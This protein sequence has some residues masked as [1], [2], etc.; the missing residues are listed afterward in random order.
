MVH[1]SLMADGIVHLLVHIGHKFVG[2][3][4]INV[5]RVLG[6]L[7]DEHLIDDYRY[8]GNNTPEDHQGIDFVVTKDGD[9]IPLQVK[10]SNRGLGKHYKKYG[11]EIPAVNGQ[12]SGLGAALR[13]LFSSYHTFAMR[14]LTDNYGSA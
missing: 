5:D 1:G 12:S 13:N 6:K 14:L 7:K 8:T 10:S 9:D 11:E 2:E 4:E 3:S